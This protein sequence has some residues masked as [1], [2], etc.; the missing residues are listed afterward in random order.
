MVSSDPTSGTF[1][2]PAG[3]RPTTAVRFDVDVDAEP[4]DHD[5]PVIP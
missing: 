1:A 3:Y 4:V 5:R 2:R